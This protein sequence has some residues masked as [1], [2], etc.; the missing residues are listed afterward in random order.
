MATPDK[1]VV[2]LTLTDIG[3]GPIFS[4]DDGSDLSQDVVQAWDLVFDRVFGH[5]AWSFARKTYKNRRRSDAPDN[6]WKY[7]FDLPGGRVG[8]PILIMDQAGYSPRALKQ[9][10]IE[11]GVLY[12]ERPETW[13]LCKFEADPSAWPPEFRSAFVVAFG[14]YLAMPVWGDKDMR[15]DRM[16]EAFGTPSKEGGGGL[17]GRLMAQDL[18]SFP[19]G[20]GMRSENSSPVI[21]VRPQGAG[22]TSS[23]HGRF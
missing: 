11:A 18:A 20:E 22:D 5:H 13:S 23:W 15:D 12:C 21:D 9:F 16:V 7:G 2:D 4:I 1:K 10:T 19:I 17:F 6:G 14:A 3:V 8:N